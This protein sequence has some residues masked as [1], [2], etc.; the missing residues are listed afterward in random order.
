M[1]WGAA[2]GRP[3]YA[4]RNPTRP[5]RCLP[6]LLLPLL[7]GALGA[8]T[9]AG[10]WNSPRTLDLIERTSTQ[11]TLPLSDAGLQGY[12]ALAEGHLYFYLD[13]PGPGNRT[14]VKADQV[15]LEVYW[16]A[17]H[18]TKQR[19][20]ARREEDR[21]P[22][23]LHYHLDHLT[24]VQD[25][26]GDA[27][28]LGDGDEVRGVPH[29]VARGADSLYD[30]RL[31][32]SLELRLPAAPEPVRV[33]E[34]EVRPRD[35]DRPAIIGS[36]FLDRATAAVV[37]MSFTFTPASYIDPRLEY[38]RVTLDNGLW[39][40]R[41]WLPNEQ[42]FEVRRQMPRF[43]LGIASVIAGVFR[44][45]DY[46]FDTAAPLSFF[47]GP[48]VVAAPRSAQDDYRFRT[49]LMAELDESVLSTPPDL[50]TIRQEAVRL[51]GRRALSALPPLRPHVDS[52]SALV[53][54]NR[55]ESLFLAGG[56][57][58]R[59]GPDFGL[60]A[61]VGFATGPDH[62]AA[63][64]RAERRLGGTRLDLR[65]FRNELRDIGHIPAVPG[66][67]NTLAGAIFG[68]DYTDP[69]YADGLWLRA[70]RP[71]GG[72]WSGTA[73]LATERHG[74]ATLH[75]EG[76][77]LDPS[78]FRPVRPIDEG[79]LAEGN[80]RV[81][82]RL[83]RM[84]GTSWGLAI[85]LRGGALTGDAYGRLGARAR[86]RWADGDRAAVELTLGGGTIMGQAPAQRLYL[87][88]GPGTVPGYGSRS[89]AGTRYALFQAVAQRALWS[90]WLRLRATA[91]AG[92][93]GGGERH[94]PPGWQV[95]NDAGVRPALGIG[96]GLF[97]DI[98]RLDLVRGLDDGFWQAVV[99]VTPG[100]RG[101]L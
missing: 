40:G 46:T 95:E 54:Y 2:D 27:I 96:A 78:G 100:L 20:I 21:L 25:E 35:F 58:W 47:S 30:Y 79:V 92:W 84:P 11:R 94:V 99:S 42:R 70:R 93:A 57:A 81:E 32:D 22:N 77:L 5:G 74:S 14:L 13:R 91:A 12:R 38:I 82:R 1:N 24:V 73:T 98:L 9:P 101:F 75:A 28:R 62:V 19:I 44:I 65:A 83:L 16:R 85:D 48:R 50:A 89:L 64:M 49:E 23:R 29:P 60:E 41:Y 31:A 59:P 10:E 76:G 63:G 17:P 80:L 88:G 61:S 37:R 56:A 66:A 97:Y 15:A 39:D 51:A 68:E 18:F 86:W 71:L 72:R 6:L 69:Y 87:L 53:R 45:H 3:A 8:Q 33:Y 7:A 4:A 67:L 55:A 36:L 34:I 43:D 52:T 26:F 90:P